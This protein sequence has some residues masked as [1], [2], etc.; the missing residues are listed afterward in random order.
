[1][2]QFDYNEFLNIKYIEDD[3]NFW[4]VRSK[5][6]VFYDEF[7]EK[8][9]VALGWNHIDRKKLDIE[10]DEKIKNEVQVLY[11]TKQGGTIFNKCSRFIYEMKIGDIV[12]VPSAENDEI[13]FATVGEYYEEELDYIK[14]I[15]TIKRIDTKEDYGIEIKCPYKK[16]RCINIIKIIEGDRLNPNLFRALTSYHG[17]SNINKYA[18]YILSSVYNLYVWNSK[19]NIV[20]NIEQKNGIDAYHYL[21]DNWFALLILYGAFSGIKIGPLEI[22]SIPETILKIKKYFSDEKDKT[23]QREGIKIDN[24]KK[25]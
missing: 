13:L 18:S 14:E 3:V 4:L 11:D 23:L 25:I 9:F 17:I 22:N 12:M 19:I 2:K 10:D 6:G 5:G 20:V 21:S 8:K 7:K 24:E 1:M 15:E 16:R